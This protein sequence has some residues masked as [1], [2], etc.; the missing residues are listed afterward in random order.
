MYFIKYPMPTIARSMCLLLPL[1]WSDRSDRNV[2][3]EKLDSKDVIQS[4]IVI[5]NCQLLEIQ[6]CV[7]E[8]WRQTST[9]PIN[10]LYKRIRRITWLLRLASSQN[11]LLKIIHIHYALMLA[12]FNNFPQPSGQHL[13]PWGY[14]YGEK[15]YF[16]SYELYIEN[17]KIAPCFLQ[18]N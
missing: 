9:R 7:K 8:T 11:F 5:L 18:E 3:R 16:G 10:F 2:Y 4:H 6:G 15:Y 14:I 13:T 17:N 1:S 12:N